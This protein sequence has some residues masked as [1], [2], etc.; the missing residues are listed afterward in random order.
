MGQ[1]AKDVDV[2]ALQ[3]RSPQRGRCLDNFLVMSISFLFVATTAL[4]VGGAMVVM[5]LRSDMKSLGSPPSV[6]TQQKQ[7]GD[8][9]SPAYKM[10]KFSYLQAANSKLGNSTMQ[11]KSIS[12]GKR[13]TVGSNFVFDP[14]RHSLTPVQ[15]GAYFMYVELNFTCTSI[16]NAGVLTV[17]VGDELTCKV[18][19]P[20]GILPVSRKCWTVAQLKN[21]GMLTQMTVQKGLEDWKL[22]LQSSGFGIF[23][24][25]P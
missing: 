11:W 6:G 13:T 4:A 23:L 5:E 19:L 15:D 16:C 10:E 25:D 1:Q 12:Y 22:E 3:E 20:E 9:S 7:T 2:E 8:A 17:K 18:E 24:I 14:E 21:Q